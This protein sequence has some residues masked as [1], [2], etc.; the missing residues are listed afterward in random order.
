MERKGAP[1]PAALV[2][3][4]EKRSQRAKIHVA[5]VHVTGLAAAERVDQGDI[6]AL[7]AVLHDIS[8]RDRGLAV[9]VRDAQPVGVRLELVE[10]FGG[11][12]GCRM[13]GASY[14]PL[15]VG[16]DLSFALCGS[17]VLP[18]PSQPTPVDFSYIEKYRVFIPPL[19]IFNNS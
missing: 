19:H 6:L 3:L 16:T 18:L 1:F 8:H 5:I 11:E 12:H 13:S 2:D 10:H 9:A 14:P 4:T 7:F 17:A 15:A